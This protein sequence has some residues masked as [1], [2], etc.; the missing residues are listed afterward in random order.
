[1][2]EITTY[3][4]YGVLAAATIKIVYYIMHRMNNIKNGR[5]LRCDFMSSV[6]RSD[7]SDERAASVVGVNESSAQMR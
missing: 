4:R 2:Y 1:M 6:M 5:V 7:V 3:N